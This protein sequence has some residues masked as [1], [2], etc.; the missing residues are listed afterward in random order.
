MN[1]IAA[2]RKKQ[3]LRSYVRRLPLLLLRDY[4]ASS[5]YSPVQVRKSIERHGLN[6]A[7]L[8]YAIAIFSD[9]ARFAEYRR[10]LGIN[11]DHKAMRDEML[12]GYLGGNPNV[13]V[14]E[15]CAVATCGY[16]ASGSGH[17]HGSG[18][19]HSHGIPG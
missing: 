19:W 1:L 14:A 8:L 12:S 3:V 5:D 17:D 18:G 10:S 4:G 15:I 6:P 7:Y 16:D 13:T 9:P 2:W 11:C